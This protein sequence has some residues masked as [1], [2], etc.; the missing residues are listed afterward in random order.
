MLIFIGCRRWPQIY[1]FGFELNFPSL[2]SFDPNA[3][4]FA[5]C[6]REGEKESERERR[7]ERGQFHKHVYTQLVRTEIPKAQKAA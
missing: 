4:L 1:L 2:T 6:K 3:T 7:R 5:K